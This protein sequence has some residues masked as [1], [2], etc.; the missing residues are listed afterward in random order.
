MLRRHAHYV[1]FRSIFGATLTADK[2]LKSLYIKEGALFN[3]T[4]ISYS[5]IAVAPA[6]C[7]TRAHLRPPKNEHS[8]HIGK[9]PTRILRRKVTKVLNFSCVR[10]DDM[11]TLRKEVRKGVS[12]WVPYSHSCF[13]K[14]LTARALAGRFLLWQFS[15]KQSIKI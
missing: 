6:R 5:L 1:F 2:G 4:I 14:L 8:L 11:A 13:E 12:K 10:K 3:F 15:L 7:T 9:D